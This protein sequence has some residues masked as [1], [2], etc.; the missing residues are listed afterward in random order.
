MTTAKA[1]T[2]AWVCVDC[3]EVHHGVREEGREAP[4]REPLNLIPED[5]E[6]TAGLLWEEHSDD[7]PNRRAEQSIVECDCEQIT[8]TWAA[9]HGCGSTLGG[10]REALTI[11]TGEEA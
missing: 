5:A 2:T 1:P 4:D 10:A 11:W 8:F 9:C 6:V 3:Y 7:C